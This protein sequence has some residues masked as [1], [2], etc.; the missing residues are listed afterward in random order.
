MNIYFGWRTGPKSTNVL[1]FIATISF[2]PNL[3]DELHI[4]LLTPNQL[5]AL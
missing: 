1:E 5:I 2:N 3:N 4:Q